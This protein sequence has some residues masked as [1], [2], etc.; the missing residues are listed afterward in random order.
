MRCLKLMGKHSVKLQFCLTPKQ[1]R[2][3]N[4]SFRY[5][6]IYYTMLVITLIVS[7]VDYRGRIIIAEDSILLHRHESIYI[8]YK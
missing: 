6:F 5:D 2:W 1:V 3:T 8:R 7:L 4:F